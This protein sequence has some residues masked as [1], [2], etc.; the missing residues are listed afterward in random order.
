MVPQRSKGTNINFDAVYVTFEKNGHINT[1]E[2][3]NEG[4][5]DAASNTFK[6]CPRPAFLE[7]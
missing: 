2:L 4:S 6:K 1:A 3:R 7:M 5:I